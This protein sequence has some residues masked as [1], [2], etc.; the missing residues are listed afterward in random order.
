MNK[1][2]KVC[3]GRFRYDEPIIELRGETYCVACYQDVEEGE[4]HDD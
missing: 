1:E 3:G 2:C 4:S